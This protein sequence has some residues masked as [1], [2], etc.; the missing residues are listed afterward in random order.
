LEKGDFISSLSQ[1]W[2]GLKGCYYWPP[3]EQI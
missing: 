2:L 1:T 3:G